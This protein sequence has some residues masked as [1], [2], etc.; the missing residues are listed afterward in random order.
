MNTTQ[1]VQ[2]HVYHASRRGNDPEDYEDWFALDTPNLRWAIADG[3]SESE[4]AAEWAR[5]LVEGFVY[6]PCL[7]EAKLTKWL[8]P[9]Q[10]QW[11]QD[12]RKLPGPW[13]TQ[14]KVEEEGGHSTL[15]GVIA[16]EKVCRKTGRTR[17]Y[18]R[19]V[20]VG[21]S[22]IFQVRSG[23]LIRSFPMEK[24]SDFDNSPILISTKDDPTLVSARKAAYLP[25]KA[26]R[27]GDT[28]LMMTDAIALWCFM[29]LENG[30]NP[31]DEIDWIL[32]SREPESAFA[33]WVEELRDEKKLKKLRND[34]TTL[35]VLRLESSPL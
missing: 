2:S 12:A 19:A 28:L 22:C 26:W 15:L 17:P 16:G 14:F 21:D 30:L 34:D 13:Y 25:G 18:W 7:S 8:G 32:S 27:P 35:I 1:S 5:I 29:L 4:F 23:N 11:L 20:A 9:L 33:A 6:N 31:F 10:E 3:A 24:S